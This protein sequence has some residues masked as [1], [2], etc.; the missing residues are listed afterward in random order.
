MVERAI[1]TSSTKFACCSGMRFVKHFKVSLSVYL[2]G[3]HGHLKTLS[4]K[5][6]NILQSIFNFSL[7]IFDSLVQ[8][9]YAQDKSACV[10]FNF[11]HFTQKA[12]IYS[13]H[14]SGEEIDDIDLAEN[15]ASREADAPIYSK[16]GFSYGKTVRFKK[17]IRKQTEKPQQRTPF[18]SRDGV[19]TNNG[20]NVH[21][22]SRD[23]ATLLVKVSYVT[24]H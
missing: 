6:S 23:E 13:I 5:I 20:G 22:H 7:D 21:L 18:F 4:L 11:P 17:R 2:L 24:E 8:V 3:K 12:Y 15:L 10:S 19:K 9:S 14:I 1:A 16:L